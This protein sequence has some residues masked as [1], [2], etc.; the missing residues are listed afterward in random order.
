MVKNLPAN[1]GRCRRHRF[2]PW[3]RKTLWRRALFFP[4]ESD[5]Q[6]SL[7]GCSPYIWSH[8]VGHDCSNLAH[9]M[10]RNFFFFNSC[11]NEQLSSAFPGPS[12][13]HILT[14]KCCLHSPFLAA[15]ISL[16]LQSLFLT[17]LTDLSSALLL[18]PQLSVQGCFVVFP[19]IASLLGFQP[20]TH[21]ILNLWKPAPSSGLKIERIVNKCSFNTE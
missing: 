1:P 9:T 3:V 7:V 15:K 18:F 13:P 21:T 14:L 8:R 17:L 19:I 12:N 20:D 11:S 6:R 2:S 10:H 4:G 5:G 16:H